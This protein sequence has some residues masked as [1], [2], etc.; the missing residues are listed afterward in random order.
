M[1]IKNIVVLVV[2]LVLMVV[3][4][5]FISREKE[6]SQIAQ[7]QSPSPSS[8]IS[9]LISPVLSVSPSK[10]P[11]SSPSTSLASS[12][13]VSPTPSTLVNID[14]EI[15]ITYTDDGYSPQSVE[16]K[17]GD[18]ISFINNSSKDMWPASAVHPTHREYPGSDIEKCDTTEV[19]NI[20]DAC[21]AIKPRGSWTFVFKEVGIWKYHDHLSPSRNGTI[22]VK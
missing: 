4:A 13:A 19:S 7:S 3:S 15:N 10:N 8:S 18:R 6:E 20:F 2:A 21:K 9:R 14:K 17:S 12:V 11:T 16:I 5:L 1:N 22:I